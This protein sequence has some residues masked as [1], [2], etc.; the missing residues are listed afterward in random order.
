M[1]SLALAIVLSCFPVSGFIDR[2]EGGL[3]VVLLP[4][5]HEL[6]VRRRCLPNGA[7]EGTVLHRGRIDGRATR[8]AA[9]EA[10]DLL[11]SVT[12]HGIRGRPP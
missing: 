8:R 10:R 2:I 9:Q 7:R 12:A 6:H 3:A 5:G 4:E 1:T 11:D